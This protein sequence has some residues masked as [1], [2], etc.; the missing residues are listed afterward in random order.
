M[1]FSCRVCDN[2][3]LY[4]YYGEGNEQQYKYYKCPNCGLVNYDLSLGLDQEQYA[5]VYVDPDD[6]KHKV[7]RYQ[8]QT[9]KFIDRHVPLSGKVLE[10]GCGNGGLLNCLRTLGWIVKGLELSPLLAKSVKHRLDIEVELANFMEY[11][12][13]EDDLN[14]LVILRHVFEHLPDPILV[15]QKLSALV[16]DSG[17]IEMEFP[18]I[19]APELKLKRFL[20][21][22]GLRVKKPGR[23]RAPGHANE[24]SRKSF[25]YLLDHTGFN[26]IKWETYTLKPISNFIY[27]FFPVG[28]KAR[29]LIQK[30]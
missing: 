23:D 10:I 17:Y 21:R 25:Q 22:F 28:S 3:K 6:S 15:L 29:V 20:W 11:S 7:N 30:I 27:K 13:K 4:F 24:F 16:K 5:E 14:D 9:C 2:D 12:P 19:E 26:L 18:N 1:S 8:R